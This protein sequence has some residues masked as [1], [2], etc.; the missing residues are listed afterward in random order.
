MTITLSHIKQLPKTDFKVVHVAN[1]FFPIVLNIKKKKKQPKKK[2]W[3][4]FFQCKIGGC[5]FLKV[6]G[7]FF[8]FN[9][10]MMIS[11]FYTQLKYLSALL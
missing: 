2:S 3:V 10:V 6:R 8:P 5:L 7:V 4:A 11:F 9:V 1:S